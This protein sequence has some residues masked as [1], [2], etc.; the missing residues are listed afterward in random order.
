MPCWIQLVLSEVVKQELYPLV[1]S[2]STCKIIPI[3]SAE[4]ER[5]GVAL[6]NSSILYSKGFVTF[7]FSMSQ[8]NCSFVINCSKIN[9]PNKLK[10][11][12][13]RISGF[14][15]PI[16]SH[17]HSNYSL[18]LFLTEKSFLVLT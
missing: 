3:T 18:V 13:S 11:K 5:Y 14:G 2:P 4:N 7:T 1:L 8:R 12:S 10:T 9:C 6:P 16:F 17:N 15:F